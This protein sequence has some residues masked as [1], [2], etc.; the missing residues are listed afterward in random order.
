MSNF[1]DRDDE[2]SYL[3]R[4][5]SNDE[6]NNYNKNKAKKGG[7]QMV[8]LPKQD[9]FLENVKLIKYKSLKNM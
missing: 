3:E 5:K 9:I 2:D 4:L 7:Y 8:F 6:H 1:E